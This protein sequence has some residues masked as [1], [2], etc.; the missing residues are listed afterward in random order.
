M[1]G[2]ESNAP[3]RNANEDHDF[4]ILSFQGGL[5]VGCVVVCL[6]LS[7]FRPI[8]TSKEMLPLFPLC[9]KV[10]LSV[11]MAH[12]GIDHPTRVN[13]KKQ[14]EAQLHDL[15]RFHNRRDQQDLTNAASHTSLFTSWLTKLFKI[16]I[17]FF[18]QSHCHSEFRS[19]F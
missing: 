10:W 19:Y 12:L 13:F 14:V 11:S 18:V 6:L 17:W 2:R 3:G 4:S 15:M 7:L 5:L 16:I 8:K 1:V 9:D